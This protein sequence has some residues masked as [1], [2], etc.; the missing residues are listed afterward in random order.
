MNKLLMES[1]TLVIST[2]AGGSSIRAVERITGFHRD[3]IMRLGVRV[4]EACTALM[5][6]MFRKLALKDIQLDEIWVFVGKKA[7]NVAEEDSADFGDT[8]TFV[9][10]DRP[11]KLVPSF[12]VGKRDGTTAFAFLSDLHGRLANRVQ[13]SSDGFAAYADA[14][15]RGFGGSVDYGQIVKTYTCPELDQRRYSPPDI[16]HA[17]RSIILAKP[18]EDHIC[19][20]HVEAQNL[21]IRMHVRRL[22]RL[23]NAFSK[24]L[25]NFKA[26]MGLHFA[27][28][29]LVNRHGAIGCTPAMA[30]G[31]LRAPLTVEDLVRL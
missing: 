20:S 26:A 5:D 16:F 23:T 21:T 8:Y 28:Y 2:L 18:V 13:L 30:A 31:V 29:N 10:I 27:Y 1:Q 11:S 4:G 3:T 24:K 7:K 17:A 6:Q 19:T 22:T 15:E 25:E 9:A 12:R 14:V